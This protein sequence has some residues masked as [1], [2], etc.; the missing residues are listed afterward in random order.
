MAISPSF[1]YLSRKLE[2]RSCPEKGGFGVFAREIIYAGELLTVW[3]GMVVKEENLNL[4]PVEKATHGIQVEEKVYLIPLGESEP[5][6][7]FNHSCHPNA[8][9]NG[10]ITLV[11]M[12]DIERGD[13]VCFDYAMSDSS[14]YD[15]FECHCETDHC[16]KK[17]TGNDWKL[18][19]LQRRY[20]GYFS[21]YLQRRI[22]RLSAHGAQRTV[23]RAIVSGQ[24]IT[25]T[26]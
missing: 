9:L 5:A 19:E 8:G 2:S 25:G 11:A 1:S 24:A 23:Q 16:R 4:L 13:E 12:R 6:D 3:G 22:D 17:I 20:K 7:M 26:D 18:P 15:E 21:P 14:D 10:Q